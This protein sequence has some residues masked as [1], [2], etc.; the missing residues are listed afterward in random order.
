MLGKRKS[1]EG[2]R[3]E[4][5]PKG[6]QAESINIQSTHPTTNKEKEENDDRLSQK[7]RDRENQK[8]TLGAKEKRKRISPKANR[9][10]KE[11]HLKRK[12]KAKRPIKQ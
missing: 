1:W 2:G 3:K 4:K 12:S 6:K 8:N 11:G 5:E 7:E 9:K 10:V